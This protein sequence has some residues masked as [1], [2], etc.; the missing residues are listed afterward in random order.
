MTWHANENGS[1]SV[2]VGA[3]TCSDGTSVSAGNYTGSPGTHVTTVNASSLT[4]GTN[5]IRVCVTDAA[6]NTSGA[7]TAPIVKDSTAPTVVV[8]NVSTNPIGV[9][10]S[11]VIS[12]H[13][14][15]SGAFSVRVGGASCTAGTQVGS[16]NYST[17][18]SS[19]STTVNASSLA[20][21]ANTIRI[22]VT[23]AAANAGSTITTVTKDIT[24]PAVTVNS[25]A[26]TII[27]PSQTATLTWHANENGS[28]SVRV[29]G[30][31]CATGAK[32][33]GGNYTNQPTTTTTQISGSALVSGSNTVRVCVTDAAGNTGSKTTILKLD[34]IAPTATITKPTNGATYARNQVVK[35]SYSC[36]DETAGSGVATCAGTVAN[37]TAI[38]T[39]SSG[40]KTF[41]V[42]VADHAGN[43]TTFTVTYT[44]T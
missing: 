42:T 30:A 41:M 18:P 11:T 16:G 12:W 39:S 34:T 43:Q 44:V 23:D 40:T 37:G 17:A 15:E 26:P 24:P 14:N 38:D 9:G 3:T 2:R 21:G 5:T 13:A 33:D 31:D 6:A 4:E 8:D 20:S 1:F 25:I 32:V 27:G 28:Y 35:A 22:C 36:K 19:S 10:G 29:G 7:P